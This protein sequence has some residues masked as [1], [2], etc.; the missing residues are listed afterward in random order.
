[1]FAQPAGACREYTLRMF[2]AQTGRCIQGLQRGTQ[3]LVGMVGTV[4]GEEEAPVIDIAAPA[5]ELG[6]LVVAQG[7]PVTVGGQ[8]RK[9]RV[10]ERGSSLQRGAGTERQVGKAFEHVGQLRLNDADRGRKQPAPAWGGWAELKPGS[11]IWP[12]VDRF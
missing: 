4:L 6:G 12:G 8:L 2:V 9:A 10:I 3:L 1:M 11:R 5:A 7:N